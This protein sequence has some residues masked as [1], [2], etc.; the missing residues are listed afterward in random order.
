MQILLATVL[1][2]I[3]FLQQTTVITVLCVFPNVKFKVCYL[4]M[5]FQNNEKLETN[6]FKY[7]KGYPGLEYYSIEE[8]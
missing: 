8:T 6:K 7:K 4:L 5:L 2:V 3:N 1:T